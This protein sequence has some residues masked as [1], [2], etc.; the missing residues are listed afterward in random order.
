MPSAATTAPQHLRDSTMASANMWDV[1]HCSGRD[2]ET[3]VDMYNRGQDAMVNEEYESADSIFTDAVNFTS[4]CMKEHQRYEELLHTFY[5]LRCKCRM[6]L[7]DYTA[8]YKD[9]CNA[10]EYDATQSSGYVQAGTAA[11]KC[12]RP[13]D[14]RTFVHAGLQVD[15]SNKSLERL[16]AQV[17]TAPTSARE[18]TDATAP[19]APTTTP[20]TPSTAAVDTDDLRSTSHDSE[21]TGDQ[22]FER[23]EYQNAAFHYEGAIN[24]AWLQGADDVK[25]LKVKLLRCEVFL[26]TWT[27][28]LETAEGMLQ[29]EPD[30]VE[31][32]MVAGEAALHLS[33]FTKAKKHVQKALRCKPP[34][35]TEVRLLA[36][37]ERCEEE[38][39]AETVKETTIPE[40]CALADNLV[41][42]DDL[43]EALKTYTRIIE[44]SV[45][46]GIEYSD[47]LA[48]RSNVH[49]K[50]GCMKDALRDMEK[51]VQVYPNNPAG[52]YKRSA[53]LYKMGE[54]NQALFTLQE[55][56]VVLSRACTNDN[57]SEDTKSRYEAL[58]KD[59]QT[60]QTRVEES[61]RAAT[62]KSFSKPLSCADASRNT[63][64]RRYL[65]SQNATQ[66]KVEIPLH[67]KATSVQYQ[68]FVKTTSPT[69]ITCVLKEDHFTEVHLGFDTLYPI[70]QTPEGDIATS[71]E[72][73]SGT[74][75]TAAER[76]PHPNESGESCVFFMTKA[77]DTIWAGFQDPSR[78]CDVLVPPTVNDGT[79]DDDDADSEDS[80][81]EDGD[82]GDG[83]TTD[84]EE[85]E[86]DNVEHAQQQAQSEE[87]DDD[88]HTV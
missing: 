19:A 58:R 32:L 74:V 56:R 36:L 1:N 8:A 68:C 27:K 41:V 76:P 21:I 12:N 65:W 11:L 38:E 62:A 84:E 57:L 44:R 13:M 4:S 80:D 51:M 50:L 45:A 14:A 39:K 3:A 43:T 88:E 33:Q 53:T 64:R 55:A 59:I 79:T 18:T 82:D 87:E 86:G 70:V 5:L 61:I 22:L 48:K 46:D 72:K 69:Q 42:N 47:V 81:S 37:M 52:Y 31:A 35:T 49:A 40:L 85:C 66:V 77:F 73:A 71:V 83:D 20:T 60:L 24:M 9:G 7:G 10:V 78:L 16:K 17:E 2:E 26:K 23:Q 75:V 6:K 30:S 67:S 29:T 54:H 34:A 63:Y 25:R 28:A 15:P